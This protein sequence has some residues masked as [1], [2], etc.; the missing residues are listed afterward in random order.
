MVIV[1]CMLAAG[2]WWTGAMLTLALFQGARECECG[3][4]RDRDGEQKETAQT[5]QESDETT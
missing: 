5:A 1:G 3:E 4:W 2:L